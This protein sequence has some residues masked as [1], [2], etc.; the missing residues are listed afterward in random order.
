LARNPYAPRAFTLLTNIIMA[1]N[2]YR[3]Q[4]VIDEASNE[5]SDD[6]LSRLAP[7]E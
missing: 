2:T 3:M 5:H 4:A 7:I 6:V 1:W